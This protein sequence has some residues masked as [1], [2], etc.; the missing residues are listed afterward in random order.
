MNQLHNFPYKHVLVLGLARSGTMAAKVLL[1][2]GYDV[3][4][5]DLQAKEDDRQVELLESLG[6]KLVLGEHPLSLLD[7]VDLIVKNPGIPY[8]VPLL[9]EAL[10]RNIP[11][12]TEVELSSY[13]ID[14]AQMI[15][16][17]GT[18]GKTTTTTLVGDFF[19]KDQ[20]AVTVA[21]NIGVASIECAQRL[22]TDETLLLEL[23]SFQLMGT[24]QFAPHIAAVLN[25]QEAHLD[26]HT[27]YEEYIDAKLNVFRRQTE[28][29]FA[30]YNDDDALLKSKLDDVKS[31]L[32]PFSLSKKLPHG[33]WQDETHLYY[34]DEPIVAKED[35][36][37]VGEHNIANI[38]AAIIIA[39]LK[40]VSNTAIRDVLAHFQGVKHR[41]QFVE[42]R[43]G[44]YFY[45][46]SKA[47]NTVAAQIALR[48]FKKPVV[49]LAGGL[50]RGDDIRH[51]LPDLKYVKA[52]VTFGAAKEK[53]VELAHLASISDVQIAETMY[54]AVNYAYD[55]S[56]E[57]DVILL[58]PACAS[59]D[60][61]ASFE[62]RGDQF[63]DA[64]NN[65]T[66]E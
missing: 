43:E 9:Q 65:L 42:R 44:R 2:E 24:K 21:G 66:K 22:A 16:I 63:I 49:W 61:Y 52:I 37:L 58:S 6:A 25:L 11:I 31:K 10:G 64:I 59:W 20:Q 19:K 57:G 8:R 38:L 32:I 36:V 40:G 47:T 12:I 30:I 41:L 29:D 34:K 48:S 55:F 50:D 28:N 46:D 1:D 17:T 39:K 35:I 18:N 33:A 14:Q 54:D 15:G 60:Q 45:N 51:L 13:I 56:S 23:S 62:E 26:Y 27:S 3:T 4:V 5:T 53:F 7:E